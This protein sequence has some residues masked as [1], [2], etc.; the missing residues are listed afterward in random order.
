MSGGWPVVVLASLLLG[1]V[2]LR[3]SRIC[4]RLFGGYEIGTCLVF[5]GLFAVTVTTAPN[6]L[7]FVGAMWTSLIVMSAVFF[8]GRET[9]WI[10]PARA[11]AVSSPRYGEI[12]HRPGEFPGSAG[13][14]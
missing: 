13:L 2:S 5:T 4:E 8:L 3:I 14:S 7:F 1:F 10:V 6:F 12:T 11:V 9:G